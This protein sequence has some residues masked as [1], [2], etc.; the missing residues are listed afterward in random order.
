M[1]MQ[2]WQART[3]YYNHVTEEVWSLHT[4][5]DGRI[6]YH[7]IVTGLLCSNSQ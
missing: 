1:F 2:V 7:N 3:Y 4:T 6:F 5:E